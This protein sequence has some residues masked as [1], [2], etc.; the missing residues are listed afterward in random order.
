MC[1]LSIDMPD[2]LK[3]ISVL[4]SPL[5]SASCC[6]QLILLAEAIEPLIII[7]SELLNLLHITILLSLCNLLEIPNGAILR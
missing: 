7:L 4:A 3:Q 6:C 5:K 2:I 1:N